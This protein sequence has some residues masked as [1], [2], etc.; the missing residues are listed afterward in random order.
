[1]TLQCQPDPAPFPEVSLR[2]G[3]GFCH[4]G[5]C[6]LADRRVCTSADR[7]QTAVTTRKARAQ[8]LLV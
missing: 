1:M 7:S 6:G 2:E 5:R 3:S 4:P 8:V